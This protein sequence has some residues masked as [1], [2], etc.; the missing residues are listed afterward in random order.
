MILNYTDFLI[1]FPVPEIAPHR[2]EIGLKRITHGA[3]MNVSRLTQ[4][5]EPFETKLMICQMITPKFVQ[6]IK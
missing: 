1:V 3:R 5:K 2:R 6:D 4:A